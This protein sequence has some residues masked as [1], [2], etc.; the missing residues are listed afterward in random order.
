MKPLVSIVVATYRR[1]ALLSELLPLLQEQT[2]QAPENAQAEILIIDNCPDRSAET[3]VAKAPDCRYV[4][5]PR[6]GVSHARNRGVTEARGDYIVFI[7]DDEAPEEGWLAAFLE[8][9]LAGAPACFGP[10]EP[11]FEVEPPAELRPLI[12]DV[13][14]RRL[15]AAD[16]EDVSARRAWLGTGNSMFRKDACF[17]DTLPFDPRFNARGGE[18]I[19]F[20]RQLAEER[21]VPLRWCAGAIVREKVPPSRMTPDYVRD[22]KFNSGQLRC[23]VEA[24]AGGLAAPTRVA[25]WMSVGAAQAAMFGTAAATARALGLQEA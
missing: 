5:E 12:E 18:D 2:A 19:W 17:G 21:G 4:H 11:W 8:A 23:L 20:L 15:N 14:S 10:V 7:D 25:F 9:A 3:T 24:G 1:Q 22:R 16:G 13:F 6:S